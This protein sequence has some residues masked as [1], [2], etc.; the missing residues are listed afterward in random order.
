MSCIYNLVIFYYLSKMESISSTNILKQVKSQELHVSTNSMNKSV[1]KTQPAS[2]PIPPI[3]PIQPIQLV[4]PIQPV[5]QVQPI[6]P[7]Q[8]IQ[9][10]QQVQP[11]PPIQQVQPVQQVPQGFHEFPESRE[12]TKLAESAILSLDQ[13][14]LNLKII[15]NIKEYDKLI[16]DD[17]TK[18]LTIDKPYVFQ[19]ILRYF[20]GNT[21]EQSINYIED[22]IQKIFVITDD[23]LQLETSS[24]H[25]VNFA[26]DTK[27][28]YQNIVLHLNQSIGGL[29]NL[30]ITYLAD[31]SSTSRI[32]LIIEKIQ[33][34]IQKIN[35]IMK[36][37]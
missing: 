25:K 23:L 15:A 35:S 4:P 19:G 1:I 29:Q 21:R 6:P 10:I 7:I 9:P 24:S 28:I 14:L 22:I 26:D 16:V 3:Q 20:N 32:Q 34:R 13:L 11:V 31:I 5:Q 33:N 36:L 17:T 30:K 2:Q 8:P 18:Q 37:S 12:P 27:S